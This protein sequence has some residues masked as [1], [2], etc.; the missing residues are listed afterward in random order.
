MTRVRSLAAAASSASFRER[1]R[2]DRPRAWRGACER[3]NM[4]QIMMTDRN[5]RTSR[6]AGT[7]PAPEF[8]QIGQPDAAVDEAALHELFPKVLFSLLCLPLVETFGV[9]HLMPDDSGQ[10]Q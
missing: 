1:H 10:H 9:R 7:L 6:M 3:V 8:V 4:N 2:S 5:V